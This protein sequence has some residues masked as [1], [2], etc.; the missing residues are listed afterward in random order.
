V[1]QSAAAA[2]CADAVLRHQHLQQLS[3][4]LHIRYS[5]SQVHFIG[6][7]RCCKCC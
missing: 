5:T 3:T 7:W 4:K 2:V 1:V 6:R